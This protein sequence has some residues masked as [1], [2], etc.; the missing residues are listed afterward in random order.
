M[1]LKIRLRQ[2]WAEPAMRRDLLRLE[3]LAKRNVNLR[4]R[5][6]AVEVLHSGFGNFVVLAELLLQHVFKSLE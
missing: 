1:F 4:P 3:V 5:F 6:G 2:R